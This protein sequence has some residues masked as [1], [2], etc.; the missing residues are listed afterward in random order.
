MASSLNLLSAFMLNVLFTLPH[1]QTLISHA[2]AD[3][4]LLLI[5]R[6]NVWRGVDVLDV[7]LVFVTEET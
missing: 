6:D 5:V 4:Q 7:S 2:A 3:G 1:L